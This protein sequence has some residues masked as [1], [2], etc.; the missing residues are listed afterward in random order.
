MAD[1][2]SMDFSAPAEGIPLPRIKPLPEGAADYQSPAG[3]QLTMAQAERIRLKIRRAK[4]ARRTAKLD[5]L[6]AQA[7]KGRMA[8]RVGISA[9]LS[10]L[11][12]L[13]G[14][15]SVSLVGGL[16][17]RQIREKA[18]EDFKRTQRQMVLDQMSEQSQRTAL[19]DSIDR[20]LQTVQQKAPDLYMQVMAGRRLPQ[21]AVVLGGERRT[22]LL[23]ELGRAMA[24]GRFT[25]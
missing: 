10:G 20:N 13:A 11:A 18:L 25:Q 12:A 19:Q 16:R 4:N 3:P 14:L 2:D 21:G 6:R 7:S 24:E 9:G 1:P 17:S 5:A 15:G 8:K 23:Q 22:D